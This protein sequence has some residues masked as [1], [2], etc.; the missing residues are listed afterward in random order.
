MYACQ[1]W[2]PQ[3]IRDKCKLESVQKFGF[4]FAAR[5]WDAGY[6]ELLDLFN[7]PTLEERR[8]HLKLGLLFKIIHNLCYFPHTP[9]LR[10]NVENLRAPHDQQ[11]AVRRLPEPIR[12]ITPFSHILYELGTHW[13]VR[14]SPQITMCHL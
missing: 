13:T 7:L 11:L 6:N 12:I 3:L 1:V 2:D 8:I 9:S 14:V 4:K 5:Q 10:E